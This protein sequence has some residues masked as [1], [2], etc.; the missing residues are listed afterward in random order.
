[1]WYSPAIPEILNG[2]L[3]EENSNEMLPKRLGR[4]FMGINAFPPV[5]KLIFPK[6]IPVKP[7]GLR[8]NLPIRVFSWLSVSAW[9][10]IS[11][12]SVT[13]AVM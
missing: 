10:I 8:E 2:L 11:E 6:F 1:M 4:L 9:I 7:N 3:S 5:K 12:K 13:F